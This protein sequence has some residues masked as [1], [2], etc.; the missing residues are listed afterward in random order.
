MRHKYGFYTTIGKNRLLGKT[1]GVGWVIFTGAA[2]CPRCPARTPICPIFAPVGLA[3]AARVGVLDTALYPHPW[4]AG[5][6]SPHYSDTFA[7]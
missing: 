3:R 2:G 1:H 4:L 7:D 6:W 5:A